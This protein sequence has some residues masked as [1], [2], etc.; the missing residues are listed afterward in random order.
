MAGLKREPLPHGN[1]SARGRRMV[2]SGVS[3][4]KNS[5]EALAY[6]LRRQVRYLKHEGTSMLV[7]N[8]PLKLMKLHAVWAP[9]LERMRGSFIS[10]NGIVSQ[11]ASR[12]PDRVASFLDGLVRKGFLERKGYL[13]L[14][15]YPPVT[16]IIPVRNRP[17]DIQT[18]LHSVLRLDYPA[19]K[20]EIIVIDDAS[21]D[22]TPEV[23]SRFPVHLI[24]LERNRHAPYCRN[25]AAQDA[26]GDILA[27]IDSDCLASPQWLRELVPTF[28][29]ESVGA[30]GGKVDSCL[31]ER[32]LDRY[33]K[34]H[35]PL[36]MGNGFKR[37]SKETPFF[38][39]PSCNLLIR[40]RLFLTLRGF[41]ERLLVGEDV[42]LCWRM[43]DAG[44]YLEY[45]PIGKVFHK[46]RNRFASFFLRR[47]DYG[48]WEPILHRLHPERVKQMGFPPAM[49]LFWTFAFLSFITDHVALLVGSGLIMLL[50]IFTSLRKAC[51]KGA[52]LGIRSIALVIFRGNLSFLYDYCA[53]VS[54][55]Y[56]LWALPIAAV[57]PTIGAAI[58]GAHV[59]TSVVQYFIR[60]PILGFPKYLLYFTLEQLAYQSGV[61][62][63]CLKY[64]RFNPVNPRLRAGGSTKIMGSTRRL[65]TRLIGNGFRFQYLMRT[66]KPGRPQA[67]SLEITHRCIARCVMC[68]IWRVP[69]DVPDLSLQ[70]WLRLLQSDLFSDLVE[71][72]IT[73][74]EPFLR[75]DL[76]DLFS[77][78]CDLRL[79]H[80]KNLRSIAVTTNGL[81]TDRVERYTKRILEMLGRPSSTWSWYTPW[82]RWER[83]TIKYGI[84]ETHGAR[85]IGRST[86]S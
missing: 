82:T 83:S 52:P 3:M 31:D 50:Q 81:L 24:R 47:F 56:L 17:Q 71:L 49:T 48:T 53:F 38:Y 25:R 74:G 19:E 21:V 84:T 18:C 14:P 16:V 13:Q 86:S 5:R 51:R 2:G 36:E 58:L 67:L 28:R 66:G 55:Y 4:T 9:V 65:V 77:G 30:V 61:W 78:L 62:W 32:G 33:E 29:D 46:H 35:S 75:T 70:E 26:S 1:R 43:H 41:R 12:S 37:S 22:E 40:G 44:H 57:F 68:D 69:E 42:D 64:L 27:F 59:V 7:L 34:V 20:L 80:L 11:L 76:P 10:L 79:K 8:Y 15:E 85:R 73:G 63:G 6:R 45:L 72:D 39:I 60:R 54:R 23:V